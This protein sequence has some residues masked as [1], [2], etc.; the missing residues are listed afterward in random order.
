VVAS[1]RAK[2]AVVAADERES[3]ERALLNLG[4]TF[5][6]AIEAELGFSD[7]L[8]HGEAVAIGMALA[9]DLSARRGIASQE[10]ARRV[11]AHL[12]KAGLPT[13]VPAGLDPR[14]LLEHMRKDKK[15]RDGK[16]VFVLVRGIGRAY[17]ERGVGEDEVLETL[18][19]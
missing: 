16:L 9:F 12:E 2:A 13:R 11:H 1:C 5:G 6:H 18:A 3:G 8:L 15:T 10:E 7:A 4:H 19:G 14:R 17:V